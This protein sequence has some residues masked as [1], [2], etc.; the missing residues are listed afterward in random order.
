MI[1]S[2]R[3]LVAPGFDGAG[4]DGPGFDGAGWLEIDD[5]IVV[6]RGPGERATGSRDGALA[7]VIP[8]FV[9]I[10]AHGALGH[11][12]GSTDA[13]G[14]AA[15]VGYHA[16]RGTTSLVASV[17]TAPLAALHEAVA[18][19]RPFVENG[20][21][22]GTHLEGPYL[23]P[24]RRGAHNPA[25]LR[26]PRIDEVRGLVDAGAGTLRMI[27]VAPELSG[28]EESIRWLAAHGV[29]VAVGHS[30]AD[31]AAARAA[32]GWGATVVTHLFNGMRPL[33]HR[34]P[35]LVGAA[36]ADDRVTVE[37]ILDGQH[38][39]AEAAEIVRRSAAGRLA[40]VSDS[41]SATGCGDGD[42]DLA[43]SAV[44][45]SNGVAT[46]VVGDSLAGSTSTVST[47]F[48]ILHETGTPLPEAVAITSTTP[49]RALGLAE[50]LAVGSPADLLVVDGGRVERVMRR[51]AWLASS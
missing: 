25:L 8:G 50:P 14:L 23:S 37:L 5:G 39:A 46:L 2:A 9:D 21:L 24:L 33:H 34:D 51:G 45:V 40:L 19:L 13:A 10:H 35:G 16:A 11:D 49:A 3:R 42:Y 7:A 31:A 30:D 43:G 38:V 4:F 17:A 15:V 27:T 26:E 22:A 28:A 29:V 36:L 1:V 47:G 44:R 20:D 32:F 48:G 12:V 18:F 41:M 6:D